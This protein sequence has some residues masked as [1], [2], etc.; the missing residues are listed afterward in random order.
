M[1]HILVLDRHS[2]VHSSTTAGRS[3]RAARTTMPAPT[4]RRSTFTFPHCDMTIRDRATYQSLYAR[5]TF[6]TYIKHIG[7]IASRRRPQPTRATAAPTISRPPARTHTSTRN[8]HHDETCSSATHS[9][10]YARAI[11]NI[12]IGQSVTTACRPS[13]SQPT[14]SRRPRHRSI[15]RYA[16]P[17]GAPTSNRAMTDSSD[18][19][20]ICARCSFISA[21]TF[22]RRPQHTSAR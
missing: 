12:N 14:V 3:T 10:R 8:L 9:G 19:A 5:T 17:F 4:S 22:D 11:I 13:A 18:C 20:H 15:S 6:D 7:S 21:L 16:P 2:L 1:M